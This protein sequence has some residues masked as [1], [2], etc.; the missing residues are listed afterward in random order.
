MQLRHIYPGCMELKYKS[1]TQFADE[2]CGS[3]E[4]SC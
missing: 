1:L 3:K 2:A 4:E